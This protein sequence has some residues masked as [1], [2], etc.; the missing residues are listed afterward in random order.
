V[1]PRRKGKLEAWEAALIKA[2][3]ARTKDIND[4]DI[5]P[6]FSRPS[7]S[8]NH[9][10]IGEIRNGELHAD[11]VAASEEEL[12]EFLLNWPDIDPASGLSLRGDELLIKAREAMI[13]AVHIFNAAGLTF[14]AE[15]FIVTSII[16]WTYL[17]HAWFKRE[18]ID[19][20]YKEKNGDVKKTKHGADCHWD[21]GFCLR[22]QKCPLEIE[23]KSN[24]DF[25]IE[26]RH[27]IEHRSTSRIDN[28]VSSKLQAACINFNDAIKALFGTQFGLEHR[29]PIAL[30]F[31]TFS[32]DQRENLK[33]ANLPKH[34]ETMMEHF[35]GGLTADQQ[36]DPRFAYRVAFVPKVG[37]KASNSDLAVEFV[38]AGSDEAKEISR[39]LLKE[40]D[41]ARYTPSQIVTKMQEE[42]FP[43]FRIHDHTELWQAEDAKNPS[44]GY[45]RE[46]DYKN[47]WVW[48]DKWLDNVRAHCAAN[49]QKYADPG[50]RL[51]EWKYRS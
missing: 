26:L 30:Q 42:G 12:D 19:Y 28:A 49:K 38:K 15:L 46:G 51:F 4:Q 33:P 29:L 20:T 18:G 37:S 41:K 40:V 39:V 25:L 16:A 36:A 23:V 17:L 34:V 21:L 32:A 13:G 48:Y 45:G 24:L 7:R 2:M 35:H 27:E 1:P 3:Q 10:E 47:A 43:R 11:V 22:H 14:R 8:V 50:G 44:K 6:Y 9:R 31:V 5:L